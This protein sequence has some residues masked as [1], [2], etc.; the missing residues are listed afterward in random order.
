MPVSREL[1]SR[2]RLSARAL[3]IGMLLNTFLSAPLYSSAIPFLYLPARI[4]TRKR[5]ESKEAKM[6]IAREY[7]RIDSRAKRLGAPA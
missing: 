7:E 5:R 2:T 6:K 1:L 3:F 4:D